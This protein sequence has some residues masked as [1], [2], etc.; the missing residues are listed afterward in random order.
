MPRTTITK[1]WVFVILA[2]VFTITNTACTFE[3]S[4]NFQANA[5]SYGAVSIIGTVADDAITESSGVVASRCNPDILWTHNDSGDD[6]FIFAM[7][8]NG[9]KAGTW[10]LPNAQ[11]FDW[12]D[13]ATTKDK[14]GKCYLYIG[15]IGDNSRKRESYAIYRNREPDVSSGDASSSKSVPRTIEAPETL[16]FTYP[17]GGHNAE[18]LMVHPTTGDIYIVTKRVSGPSTVYKLKGDFRGDAAATAEKVSDISFPAIPNGFVTGGD[19]SPDGTR[20]AIC[21]YSAVYELVLLTASAKFDTIWSSPIE[22]I[23]VGSR[24]VG[25]AIAYTPD[26][27]SLILTSEGKYKPILVVTRKQ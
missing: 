22:T 9:A 23:D 10:K 11:N 13:I 4:P 12:E 25:E 5:S 15:E 18:T 14:D 16:R 8:M 19:I 1:F 27:K 3:Q 7:H 17:D 24:A 2:A 21:D 20:V 6:A 26:G